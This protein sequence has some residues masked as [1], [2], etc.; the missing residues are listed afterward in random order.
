[1]SLLAA[2]AH[3]PSFFVLKAG[4][5]TKM[6]VIVCKAGTRAASMHIFYNK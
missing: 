5:Y 6:C 2:H 3:V 4:S 1:M